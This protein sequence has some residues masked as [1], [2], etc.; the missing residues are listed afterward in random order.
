MALE[1]RLRNRAQNAAEK[2]S[3]SALLALEK[4]KRKGYRKVS[5]R[6]ATVAGDIIAGFIN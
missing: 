4:R 3:T 5:K 6:S 2:S 1:G